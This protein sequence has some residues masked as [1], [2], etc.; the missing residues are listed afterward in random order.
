MVV[1]KKHVCQ[2]DFCNP[3]GFCNLYIVL[4]IIC[5]KNLYDIYS[6]SSDRLEGTTIPEH[7]ELELVH[8]CS[9]VI[10]L[11]ICG[12]KMFS[13]IHRSKRIHFFSLMSTYIAP[14]LNVLWVAI[15]PNFTVKYLS[16]FPDVSPLKLPIVIWTFYKTTLVSKFSGRILSCIH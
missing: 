3:V 12:S 8:W 6:P 9:Q 14:L 2:L 10:L 7:I 16:A 11:F 5:N 1:H 15:F 13:H 4:L